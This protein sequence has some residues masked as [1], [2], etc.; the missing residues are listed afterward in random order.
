MKK[1]EIKLSDFELRFSHSEGV[2][3][4]YS[5]FNGDN[6][7]SGVYV[8][9]DKMIPYISRSGAINILSKE[10]IFRYYEKD[11]SYKE[12]VEKYKKDHKKGK[13]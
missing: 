12:I 6:Y 1:I 4:G 13:L 3:D 5:L 11:G 10:T 2:W 7:I 8:E 9:R